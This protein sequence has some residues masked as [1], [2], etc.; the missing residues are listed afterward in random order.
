MQKKNALVFII[1]H[2]I[3]RF[4]ERDSLSVFK[5]RTKGGIQNKGSANRKR[6]AMLV[7][8]LQNTSFFLCSRG[9]A[10]SSSSTLQYKGSHFILFLSPLLFFHI[11]FSLHPLL[12]FSLQFIFSLS[13]S[14]LHPHGV[15][16]PPYSSVSPPPLSLISSPHPRPSVFSD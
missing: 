14:S 16:F 8:T 10:S 12:H 3:I 1:I 9:D 11:L 2:N 6:R 13:L 4:S 7:H 5:R 15:L